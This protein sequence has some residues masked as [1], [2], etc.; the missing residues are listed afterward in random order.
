MSSC[1]WMQF[2]H[3]NAAFNYTSV[4]LGKPTCGRPT[5]SRLSVVYFCPAAN[6]DLPTPVHFSPCALLFRPPNNTLSESTPKQSPVWVNWISSKSS[7]PNAELNKVQISPQILIVFHSLCM[8]SC[9]YPLTFSVSKPRL[10]LPESNNTGCNVRKKW[11]WG[12]FVQ[13]LL[14]WK[15][16]NYYIFWVC[17]CSLWYPACNSHA[18]YCRL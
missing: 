3:C 7:F 9:S 2:C 17:V 15:S 5:H 10:H 8:R 4:C 16:N 6:S 11:H 12:T 13:P 1:F 18:P 14:Q